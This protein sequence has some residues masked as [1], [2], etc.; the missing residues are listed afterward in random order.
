MVSENIPLAQEIQAPDPSRYPP[1]E[2]PK[3]ILHRSLRIP[4]EDDP[5]NR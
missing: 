2:H 5:P 1:W 4:V 3:E